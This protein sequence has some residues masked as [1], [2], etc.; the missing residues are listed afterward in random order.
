MF[1]VRDFKNTLSFVIVE[2]VVTLAVNVLDV[3]FLADA[4]AVV[5]A[6]SVFATSFFALAVVATLAVIFLPT[7]FTKEA[8]AVILA[9]KDLPQTIA[10]T[11]LAVAVIFAV[12]DFA[13]IMTLAIVDVVVAFA[14]SILPI[15]RTRL[16]V[17]N[18]LAVSDLV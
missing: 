8:V 11:M 12:S 6:D 15:C 2:L 14:V 13:Q 1:A 18:T 10:L 4:V 16:A 17:T 7:C 5:F 3:C 9:V